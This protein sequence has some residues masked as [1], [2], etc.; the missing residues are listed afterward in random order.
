MPNSRRILTPNTD[1]YY[2]HFVTINYRNKSLRFAWFFWPSYV[3]QLRVFRQIH[4]YASKTFV[5]SATTQKGFKREFLFLSPH[6][7][8]N[9]QYILLLHLLERPCIN[10]TSANS[11]NHL[12]VKGIPG[13]KM[14]KASFSLPPKLPK[15]SGQLQHSVNFHRAPG[16][17]LS[18]PHIVRIPRIITTTRDD[19]MR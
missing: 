12:P 9:Q 16:V 14:S 18:Y 6:R 11:S 2:W 5:T 13:R 8:N 1:I 17:I 15:L 3:I 7:C 19:D 10:A 4:S